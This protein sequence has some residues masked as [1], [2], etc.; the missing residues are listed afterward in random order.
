LI[1]E[2]R[3]AWSFRIGSILRP[4]C[5]RAS[6]RIPSTPPLNAFARVCSFVEEWCATRRVGEILRKLGNV[7]TGA[8]VRAAA[9]RRI[10]FGVVEER[11]TRRVRHAEVRSL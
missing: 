11:L 8:D 1:M 7:V 5:C 9:R 2:N 4:Q 10:V 3:V 6:S